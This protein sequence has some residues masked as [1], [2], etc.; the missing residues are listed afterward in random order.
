MTC[1]SICPLST[2]IGILPSIIYDAT[3]PSGPWHVSIGTAILLYL[4]LLSSNLVFHVPKIV[5][6]LI[7]GSS[8]IYQTHPTHL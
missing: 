2:K 3:A 4:Q 8:S 7:L 6:F 5:L 1:K